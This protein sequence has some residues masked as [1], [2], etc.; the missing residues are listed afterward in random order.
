MEK[1]LHLSNMVHFL[2]PLCPLILNKMAFNL[3]FLQ[4][5]I[6]VQGINPAIFTTMALKTSLKAGWHCQTFHPRK[7]LQKL[8]GIAKLFQ[9]HRSLGPPEAATSTA[10]RP[11]SSFPRWGCH[12]QTR[13]RQGPRPPRA[14]EALPGHSPPWGPAARR[15]HSPRPRAL[16]RT[17]VSPR[18]SP[19]FATR[20]GGTR[21][22]AGPARRAPG[23]RCR[24]GR[25]GLTTPRPPAPSPAPARPPWRRHTEGLLPAAAAMPGK[26]SPPPSPAFRVG[27]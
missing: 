23:P 27:R 19:T 14:A 25:P 9:L 1:P 3:F 4:K 20:A 24:P 6:E 15:A 2:C 13:S 8:G 16:L 12:R 21:A 17:A 11:Y 18:R 7:P 5:L 10:L 26:S 22:V